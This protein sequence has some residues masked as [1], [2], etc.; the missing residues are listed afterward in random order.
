MKTQIYQLLLVSLLIT[1]GC[2]RS[3]DMPFSHT[4]SRSGSI[5]MSYPGRKVEIVT[6]DYELTVNGVPYG[7]VDDG[8]VITEKNGEVYRNGVKLLP[9]GETD[10]SVDQTAEQDAA[11]QPA[12]AGESR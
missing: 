7:R 9:T 4:V 10:R 5:T 8:D 6:E 1:T 11:E 3:G 2:D 12:T